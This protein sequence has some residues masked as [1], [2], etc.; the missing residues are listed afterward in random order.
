M[1]TNLLLL[2][3]YKNIEK[4]IHFAFSFSSRFKRKLKIIYV[5]DFNW[6]SQSAIVGA[7]GYSSAAMVNVERSINVEFEKDRK[8]V[9]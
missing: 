6:M 7:S 3:S 2:D 9:V 1:K 8:S 5:H 4:L